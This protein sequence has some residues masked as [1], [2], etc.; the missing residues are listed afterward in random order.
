M[1]ITWENSKMERWPPNIRF[2]PPTSGVGKPTYQD[3]PATC[4]F[5]RRL[6]G[7]FRCPRNT[8]RWQFSLEILTQ[9]EIAIPI[10]LHSLVGAICWHASCFFFPA[11]VPPL[12]P[13]LAKMRRGQGGQS[14][15]GFDPCTGKSTVPKFGLPTQCTRKRV[16]THPTPSWNPK[17]GFLHCAGLG[18]TELQKFCVA[19]GQ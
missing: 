13:S 10:F 15:A 18:A 17:R 3:L 6:E 19:V 16:E 2:E 11:C 1:K 12:G 14:L 8:G 9:R 4:K 5:L 7:K